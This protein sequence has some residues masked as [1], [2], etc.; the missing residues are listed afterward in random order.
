MENVEVEVAKLQGI[1]SRFNKSKYNKISD[2]E[3]NRR[4]YVHGL[5]RIKTVHGDRIIVTVEDDFKFFLPASWA[6]KL[7]DDDLSHMNARCTWFYIVYHGLTP[8]P[9]GK[10]K[11]DIEFIM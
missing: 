3:I 8:L 1:F 7:T 9:N 6:D 10:S 11:H 4:Y 2:L 5:E